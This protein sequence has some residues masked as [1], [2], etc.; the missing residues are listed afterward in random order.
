MSGL[1]KVRTRP[2]LGTLVEIKVS[3][4]TR[5]QA[6]RARC[7]FDIAV[8]DRLARSRCL[9]GGAA[10]R[11]METQTDW[12]S[13]RLLPGRVRLATRLTDLGC[14][15]KGVAVDRALAARPRQRAVWG[16][17]G[18]GGDLHP[19]AATRHIIDPRHPDGSGQVAPALEPRARAGATS[20]PYFAR[21]SWRGRVGMPLVQAN[22]RGWTSL[23]NVTRGARFCMLAGTLTGNCLRR[24]PGSVPRS[25][26]RALVPR[27]ADLP[28]LLIAA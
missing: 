26:G 22:G 19:A 23:T 18:T 11:T 5:E 9:P 12:R 6:P 7:A 2:L 3:A 13:L 16:V 14:I 10:C 27:P 25:G 20:A 24:N 15:A 21:R 8:A 1:V 4:L 17:V 28:G